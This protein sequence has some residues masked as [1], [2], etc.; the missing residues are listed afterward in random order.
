M[1]NA[2]LAAW[3]VAAVLAVAGTAHAAG[4]VRAHLAAP[5]AQPADEGMTMVKGPATAFKQKGEILAVS[6]IAA[7]SGRPTRAEAP[8][9]AEPFYSNGAAKTT[10]ETPLPGALWL[11]GGA[12]LAFLGIS[13]RRRF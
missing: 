11:F 7:S 9:A 6:D 4:P 8:D 3:G 2:R 10:S 13:A 12:L 1:I 5:A